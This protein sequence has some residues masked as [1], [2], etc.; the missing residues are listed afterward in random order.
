MAKCASRSALHYIVCVCECVSRVAVRLGRV[1]K[2]VA[3]AVGAVEKFH[4]SRARNRTHY[5]HALRARAR[6][7]E[8]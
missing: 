2:C 8:L 1:C 4:G 3:A 5:A 6:S 7:A